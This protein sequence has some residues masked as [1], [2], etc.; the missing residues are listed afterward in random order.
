MQWAQELARNDLKI[1]FCPGRLNRKADYLSHHPENWLE[2]RGNKNPEPI[3]KPDN[4]SE[5]YI[6]TLAHKD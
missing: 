3:L 4:I 5:L 2:E 6:M 1:Y